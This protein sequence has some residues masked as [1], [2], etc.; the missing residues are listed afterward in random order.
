MTDAKV[1]TTDEI[2]ALVL[3]PGYSSTRAGFAGEDVPKSVI[4]SHYGILPTDLGRKCLFG[5]NA[6]HTPL[7]HLSIG[8]PMASDGTVEDWDTATQLWEYAITSRLTNAKPGNPLTNGLNDKSNGDDDID[9]SDV[10]NQEK[11]L[12]ENPLLITETGWNTGKGREKGIEIAMENW[13]CP[14]FWLARTGVLAAFSAG[15]PSAL[16]IDIGASTTSITPVHDGLILKKGVTHSHLAG[17]FISDQTRL[18]FSTSQPPIQLIP[19]YLVASKSPVDA[20]AQPQAVYR[21]LNPQIAPDPSFRR[22][23]ES[24]LLT[25][26]KESVVQ[27]FPGRLGSHDQAGMPNLEKARSQPG[28]PF[29]FPDGSNQLFGSD[30][31]RVTE[32][33]FDAKLALTDANNPAPQPSQTLPALIQ[34]SLQQVDVD[35]R[36]HL[37]ANVVVTGGSSLVYGINERLQQEISMA[38]PG[39]RVKILAPGNSVERKFAAWIGGSILASLGTF[40]QMWISKKEYDEHGP[41]IVEKRCK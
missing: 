1:D 3:D 13:G 41:G 34:S 10:E 35:I 19:H 28:R 16:V 24:R 17:N 22:L 40:H 33:L 18:L 31:Y 2:S 6:I 25:E 9:M 14:A 29:E 39:P 7:P 11:P 36:P 4:P 26:F 38:Y 15:K 27:V 23:Q 8:N 20:G 12:E 37:L 5:D 30:R 21:T 32:G